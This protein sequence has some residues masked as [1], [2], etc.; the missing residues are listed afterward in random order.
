MSEYN[1]SRHQL[2]P[3]AKDGGW[4]LVTIFKCIP[5]LLKGKVYWRLFM[6][7]ESGLYHN[8]TL[9]FMS[10]H[11]TAANAALVAIG[12][13]EV[14]AQRNVEPQCVVGR[15]VWIHVRYKIRKDGNRKAMSEIWPHGYYPYRT[16][17]HWRD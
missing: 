4:R 15:K 5:R 11:G 12:V 9:M 14:G 16:P 3:G 7:E 8:D 1:I 10:A 13:V 6:K 2:P 17:G